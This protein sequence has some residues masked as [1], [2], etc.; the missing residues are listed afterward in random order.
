MK[1]VPLLALPELKIFENSKDS[2][3]IYETVN[4]NLINGVFYAHPII[5]VALM[6]LTILVHFLKR[7]DKESCFLRRGLN[8]VLLKN[9]LT[10][11]LLLLS[12]LLLVTGGW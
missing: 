12:L 5:L 2:Q 4:T 8:T 3:Y 9:S 7:S 6:S 10:N 11:N 1:I